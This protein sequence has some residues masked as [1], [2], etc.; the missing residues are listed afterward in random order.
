MIVPPCINKFYIL[1]LSPENSFVRYAVER[2]NTVFMVSWR[3]IP[4]EVGHLAWDDYLRDGVIKALTVAREPSRGATRVNALGFCVGGTM[5]GA[6][7]AVL[8]A[9][10][11]DLVESATFLTTMLD[12]SDVGDIGVVRRRDERAPREATIGA[13]RRE[14]RPRSRHRVQRAAAERSRLVVRREQ[15]PQGK[16]PPA[17]DIL[18]WNSDSTNLPGPWYCWYL[19]NTYLENNLRVPGKLEMCGV[20]VDLGKVRVPT[21]ILATREDHIVPWKTSY[22]STQLLRGRSGSC[23]ARAD[24]SPASSTRRRRTG[25]ATGRTTHSPGYPE[26]GSRRRPSTPG[27]WWTDWDRWLARFAGGDAAGPGECGQFR[28]PA[29]R[30]RARTVCQVQGR[31]RTASCRRAQFHLPV[32]DPGDLQGGRAPL[33][34]TS[35]L[36]G[37]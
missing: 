21:Y 25:A 31:V 36:P 29:E 17:F 19:R 28:I 23:S 2:G 33:I 26:S 12:F 3:N 16:A 20:R 9:R 15:L 35:H 13:G 27:S 14:G 24:T 22:L 11:E 1:D 10:G 18:Y 30:R 8:A 34:H 6:A 7:L 5:L 32:A 37:R 4:P